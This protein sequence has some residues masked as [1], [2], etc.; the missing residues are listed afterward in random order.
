MLA[1]KT[2]VVQIILPVKMLSLMRETIQMMTMIRMILLA[3]TLSLM[4]KMRLNL[5]TGRLLLHL[6]RKEYEVL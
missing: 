1:R 2:T 4:K 6:K 5:K 3:K